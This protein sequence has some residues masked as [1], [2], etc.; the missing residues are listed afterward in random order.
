M[1]IYFIQ[2]HRN[3]ARNRDPVAARTTS[4]ISPDILANPKTVYRPVAG[5][6]VACG[7]A[8]ILLAL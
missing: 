1:E 4:G 7:P 5:D 8:V 3:S 2:C 6:S